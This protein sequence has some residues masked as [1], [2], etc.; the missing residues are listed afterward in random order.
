MNMKRAFNFIAGMG[1]IFAAA[2]C[3]EKPLHELKAFRPNRAPVITNFTS[4][5]SGADL[6]P[7]ITVTVTMEAQDPEG[8]PVDIDFTSPDG[9]FMNHMKT[10]RGWSADFVIGS[11]TGGDDVTVQGR[12]TDPKGAS[13]TAG[14]SL[15]KSKTGPVVTQV[16]EAIT[17]IRGNECSPVTF[18]SDSSGYYQVALID[19]INGQAVMDPRKTFFVID[20]GT[21]V[22]VNICGPSY[23]G[24]EYTPGI[25]RLNPV[26]STPDRVAI[27]VRDRMD[28]TGTLEL[29]FHVAGTSPVPGNSGKIDSRDLR[30]DSVGL[31]WELAGDIDTPQEGLE[32]RVWYSTAS[33]LDTPDDMECNGIPA[34]DWARNINSRS[35]INLTPLT[36]YWF[37]VMVRDGDGNRSA[38]GKI[39]I[40]T[41]GDTA[42]VPGNG[43][44]ILAD[45]IDGTRLTLIW[46]EAEDDLTPRES[47]R[48][49]IYVSDSANI[50]VVEDVLARGTLL[51]DWSPYTTMHPFMAANL[52]DAA[53][54]NFNI[55]VR[56]TAGNVAAYAM[57]SAVTPDVTPPV[58]GNGGVISVSNI[59]PTAVTLNMGE[60][61]G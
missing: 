42:P 26:T 30:I 41:P 21:D 43:G 39:S 37:N 60:G 34:G 2:G 5:Y 44:A 29:I 45:N 17:V 25:P 47:L 20:A 31:T 52:K 36:R 15:G 1:L 40:E 58:P 22:T 32:Y 11:I 16:G 28:Q 14:I 4:T 12:A 19:D 8:S 51:M 56:D 27:I 33:S 6:V 24:A 57:K 53:V 10:E 3:D 50:G 13:V 59:T 54:Y 18:R 9:S 7:G 49:S 48:Y 55:L 46:T 35:I 23:A 61:G 38:Y